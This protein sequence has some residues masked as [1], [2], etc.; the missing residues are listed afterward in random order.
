MTVITAGYQDSFIQRNLTDGE[1]YRN[2]YPE[3]RFLLPGGIGSALLHI[4][5]P[6]AS[7]EMIQ[8]EI[9]S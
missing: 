5:V 4:N 1:C 3:E 7:N 6:G 2:A 8:A 9:T